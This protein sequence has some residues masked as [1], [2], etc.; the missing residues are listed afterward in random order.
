M[1]RVNTAERAARGRRPRPQAAIRDR[2]R[3]RRALCRSKSA[4]HHQCKRGPFERAIWPI[5]LQAC[6]IRPGDAAYLKERRMAGR[7]VAGRESAKA[8]R[9]HS[10]GDSAVLHQSHR[11]REGRSRQVPLRGILSAGLVLV[12]GR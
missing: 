10:A 3:G 8:L 7:Q 6:R 12:P 11:R 5:G 4:W 1:L 2:H 9:R